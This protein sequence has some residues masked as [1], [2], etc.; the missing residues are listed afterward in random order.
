MRLAYVFG[1]IGYLV[2]MA[3]AE[4]TGFFQKALYAFTIYG[5]SITP[6]LV[7]AIVWPRATKAGAISSILAGTAV[8]LMWS[9]ADWLR[10]LLPP[11]I[12]DLEPMQ[13][14]KPTGFQT[15]PLH[16]AISWGR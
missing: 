6:A 11:S 1:V 2:T 9:E 13:S 15:R 10:R 7:A 4:T 14:S 16:C 8:S 12:S 3:F 5:A